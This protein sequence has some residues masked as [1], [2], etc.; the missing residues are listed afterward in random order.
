MTIITSIIYITTA[1]EIIDI[2]L[3]IDIAEEVGATN[4][5]IMIVVA[6]VLTVVFFQPL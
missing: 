2:M 6:I 3:I 5:A 4:M 1:I